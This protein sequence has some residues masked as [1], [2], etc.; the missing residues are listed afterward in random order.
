LIHF[1]KRMLKMNSSAL[2]LSHAK[3][4][5]FGSLQYRHQSFFGSRGGNLDN[6]NQDVEKIAQGLNII[7]SQQLN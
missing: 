7:V 3:K 1:Y 2:I 4:I 5:C 6:V